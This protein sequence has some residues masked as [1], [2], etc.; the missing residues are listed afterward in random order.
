MHTLLK[1][2]VMLWYQVRFAQINRY[3]IDEKTDVK[4][5]Y[6]YLYQSKSC[7]SSDGSRHYHQVKIHEVA[8]NYYA[9]GNDENLNFS[10]CIA[11][12]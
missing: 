11:A 7:I 4:N 9:C 6:G 3:N 2:R 8:E 12:H 5:R 10:F 1:E